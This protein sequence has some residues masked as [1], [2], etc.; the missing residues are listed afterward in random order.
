M[1]KIFALLSLLFISA[2][3]MAGWEH[4]II[5][6]TDS[7]MRVTFYGP[8][9]TGHVE[10]TVKAKETKKLDSG[11]L[12]AYAVQVEALG[13]NLIGLS[14]I[15]VNPAANSCPGMT[16]NISEEKNETKNEFGGT[17]VSSRIVAK[18]EAAPTTFVS[19]WRDRIILPCAQQQ[20]IEDDFEFKK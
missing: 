4:T 18:T 14:S 13:G 11:A 19:S 8:L 9:M 16:L 10:T 20:V 6:N 17:K 12:C 2:S 3:L 15:F 1:K 5:N 7:V